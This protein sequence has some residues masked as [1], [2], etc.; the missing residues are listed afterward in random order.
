MQYLLAIAFAALLASSASAA[1]L[2]KSGQTAVFRVK[3]AECK[4][5]AKE[6]GVKAASTDFYT[7]MA[8]CIDKVTVTVAAK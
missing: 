4:S 2:S 5:Q 1:E 6:A 7:F 8:G 3:V